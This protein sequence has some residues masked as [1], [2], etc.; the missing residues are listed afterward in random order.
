MGPGFALHEQHADEGAAGP[1]GGHVAVVGVKQ[2][3]AVLRVREDT[4]ARAGPGLVRPCTGDLALEVG[5]G[6]Q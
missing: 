2:L 3:D 5:R 1:L 4:V 6:A